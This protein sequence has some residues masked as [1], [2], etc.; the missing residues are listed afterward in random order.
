MLLYTPIESCALVDDPHAGL[1]GI[2][3]VDIQADVE[4]LPG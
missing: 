1:A 4:L 2:N 3:A